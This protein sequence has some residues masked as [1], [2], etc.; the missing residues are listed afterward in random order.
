MRS[1]TFNEAGEPTLLFVMGAGNRVDGI[2]ERWFVDRLANAGYRVH[3]IQLSVDVTDFQREYRA[4]V[5]RIHDEQDPAGVLSHSLGGLVAA[6]LE[7]SAREVYLSPWWGIYEGK[8]SSWERWLVPR[9]P[10]CARILPA[11]T[12]REEIGVH[13]SDEDW[14]AIPKRI[15]PI[16]IAEIDR[17]QRARPPIDD[18]ATVFVSLEDTIISILAVGRAVPSERIRLYDGGHQL[19]SAAGRREAVEEVLAALPP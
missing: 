16:F 15:S 9:L 6:Y 7:T 4:P 5:Q 2:S 3:A 1:R 17:A 12:D 10:V 14:E 11:K 19:F 8:V 13:L 18:D